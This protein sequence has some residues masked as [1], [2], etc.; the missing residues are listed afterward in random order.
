MD[1]T[2]LR[3]SKCVMHTVKIKCNYVHVSSTSGKLLILGF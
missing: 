1:K 3:T 2:F